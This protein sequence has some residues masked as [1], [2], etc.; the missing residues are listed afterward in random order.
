MRVG[1]QIRNIHTNNTYTIVQIDRVDMGDKM[2]AVYEVADDDF[3]SHRFNSD[4][5][6]NYEVITKEE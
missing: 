2:M 6:K 4:Y 1:Q 3:N 5:I